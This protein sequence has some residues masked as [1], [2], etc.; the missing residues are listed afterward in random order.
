MFD[1]TTGIHKL[2][3]ISLLPVVKFCYQII[4]FTWN[5][6]KNYHRILLLE[7][8]DHIEGLNHE[9][10]VIHAIPSEMM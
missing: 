10:V 2:K 4:D 6:Y 3:L 1:K 8:C 7:L 5:I 9:C